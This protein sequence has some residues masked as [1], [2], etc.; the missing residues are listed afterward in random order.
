MAT[1]VFSAAADKNYW[2]YKGGS[3]P[4][5]V[6]TRFTIAASGADLNIGSSWEGIIITQAQ[7]QC[8]GYSGN[9]NL[10]GNI[11]NSSGNSI[12]TSGAVAGGVD[13]SSPFSAKVFNFL[14]LFLPAGTYFV[15]F[16][17]ESGDWMAWDSNSDNPYVTRYTNTFGQSPDGLDYIYGR[18]LIGSFNYV[19]YD[20]G[21]LDFSISQTDDKT[22]TINWSGSCGSLGKNVSINWGDSSTSSTTVT[23]GNA[24]GSM[25]HTYAS[26]GSHTVTATISYSDSRVGIPNVVVAHS[27]SVAT[28]PDA[29]ATLTL[30]P[31]AYAVTA[32]Y[33]APASN[34]GSAVIG[35]EYSTDSGG[36]WYSAGTSPFNISGKAGVVE[37]VWLRALNIWGAGAYRSATG[38]P[39]GVPGAP[40]VSSVSGVGKITV[41]Y[42]PPASN[43]GSA[44]T[45]YQYS[46]DSKQTWST[47]PSN[48]FDVTGPNGVGIGVYVRAVN[49]AGPGP[50][51]YTYA[52]PYT[53]PDAP[54]ITAPTASEVVTTLDRVNAAWSPNGNGGSTITKYQ[55]SFDGTNYYDLPAGTSATITGLSRRTGYTLRIRAVNAAGAGAAASV[56]FTTGGGRYWSHD[57]SQWVRRDYQFRTT[58]GAWQKEGIKYW[59]G[60]SWIYT[61]V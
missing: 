53:V 13:T 60:S 41:T 6:G 24:P 49:A 10:Y 21:N 20:S 29:P 33:T 48:P 57:G 18:T 5:G 31:A 26:S 34:G 38:T 30:T 8:S 11:W 1:F 32:T 9:Y 16:S 50:T 27:F 28:V 52:G 25:S 14:D 3:A 40:G 58:G 7:F 45:S 39:Y 4:A 51:G 19:L 2:E 46:K 42:T 22:V 55:Y 54:T 56:A 59:N 17:R 61:P 23:A 44:I 12:R 43:G 35:Y 15:G 47:V 36:T 37:T